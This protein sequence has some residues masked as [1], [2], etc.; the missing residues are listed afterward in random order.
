MNITFIYPN[1]MPGRLGDLDEPLVFALLAGLTPPDVEQVLYDQRLE[2][3]P[4]D[5]PTNLVALSVNTFAAKSAYQIALQYRRRGVPVVMGGHHPTLLPEESL[6]FATSIVRGDAEGVWAELI[7]DAKQGVL[8]KVYEMRSPSLVG[9][10]LHRAIFKGKRYTPVSLVQFGRGCRFACDFCSV[11]AFYGN[12]IR[13]RPIGEV[14]E[15]IKQLGRK[16]VFIID[17]NLFNDIA[18]AKELFKALEPLHIRW[19]CQVSLDIAANRGLVR[20]MAESGCVSVLL[21]F[22]SLI[23]D[24]LRQM[25]K[26]WN[27]E[28]GEY[29]KLVRVFYDY[30]IMIHGSFVFGYDYDSVDSIPLSLDFAIRQKILTARFNP[31]TPL[32]GTPLYERLRQEKRLIYDPWWIHPDFR[33]GQSWFHPKQMTAEQLAEGC[34]WARTQFNK[35]GS[36]LRRG[37]NFRSNSHTFVNAC[38]FL[39]VNWI[40]KHQVERKF[41]RPL[42]YGN[43]LDA[44]AVEGILKKCSLGKICAPTTKDIGEVEND[45]N[46]VESTQLPQRDA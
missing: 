5:E 12:D 18:T 15:E 27:I 10:K 8:K 36:I 31:A 11:H 42:G 41:G 46:A 19:G 14:V 6:Q 1:M 3:V 38:V 25:K 33:Y 44:S 17:D 9:I 4:F 16:R 7:E 20:L 40:T 34:H 37:L 43:A 30:G 22:E 32:P 39:A 21:G 45:K 13:Q 2:P 24:N 23:E 28:Y 35:Y 26:S 29:D